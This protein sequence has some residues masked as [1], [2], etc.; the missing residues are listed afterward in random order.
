MSR[1][2]TKIDW[3]FVDNKLANFWVGTEI[4]ACLGITEDTLYNRVKETFNLDF[5]VYRAQ[6]RAKGEGTLRELQLKAAQ[7]GNVTMLIWLGKQYL[8]QS[9]K[10]DIKAELKID[11]LSFNSAYNRN[12]Q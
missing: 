10:Q 4:A 9:D 11:E 5:S 7:D 12:A 8:G 6:K 3:V 1:E 2:K